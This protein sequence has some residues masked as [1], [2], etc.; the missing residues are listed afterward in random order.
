MQTFILRCLS[1]AN[2]RQMKSIA[3]PALGTGNLRYPKDLVAKV[4]FD[5]VESFGILHPKTRLTDVFFVLYHGDQ[6]TV[7]VRKPKYIIDC[8]INPT[9]YDIL[10]YFKHNQDRV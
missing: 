9:L 3:F 7:K 5:T 4:M 10:Y 1:E 2:N 6:E 8:V